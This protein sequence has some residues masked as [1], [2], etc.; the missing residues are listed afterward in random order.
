MKVLLPCSERE[1][2]SPDRGLW[3]WWRGGGGR[4]DVKVKTA[5]DKTFN[6]KG[7][8]TWAWHPEGI[9]DVKVLQNTKDDPAELEAKFEPVFIEAVEAGL[10]PQPVEGH[11]RQPD[12]C[13]PLPAHRA[14]H[15]G[16]DDGQFKAG[17]LPGVAAVRAGDERHR[18]LRA[19]CSSSTSRQKQGSIVGR[20]ALRGRP[21]R[22]GG[23]CRI[24]DGIASVMKVRE[25]TG[26]RGSS[27]RRRTTVARCS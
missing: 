1:C 6:F 21:R 10:S 14:R 19:D 23:A 4:A 3:R 18:D 8:S 24:R 11:G 12:L 20:F 7:L 26:V 13:G 2:A 25:V 22:T 27:P 9:G 5:H 15:P 17:G 16:A